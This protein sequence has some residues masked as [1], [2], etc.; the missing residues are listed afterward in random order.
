MRRLYTIQMWLFVS[1]V[2]LGAGASAIAEDLTHRAFQF[3]FA[4]PVTPTQY[5]AGRVGALAVWIFSITF[6]PAVLL[7]LALVGTA[8]S[9]DALEQRAACLD[10][11]DNCPAGL[12]FQH[13]LCKQ[14]NQRVARQGAAAGIHDTQPIA[15]PIE[16]QSKVEP[17]PRDGLPQIGKVG[18]N[19]GIRVMT[20]KRSINMRVQQDVTAGETSAQAFDHRAGGAVAGIPGDGEPSKRVRRDT[21]QPGEQALDVGIQHVDR[22]GRPVAHRPIPPGGEAAEIEYIWTEERTPV[23]YH[24]EAILIGGIVTA[25]YLNAILHFWQ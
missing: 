18:I 5:L 21:P 24:L 17:S 20:R 23:K 22:L 1:L 12:P 19:R 7:D 2:T 10:I 25:G 14:H 13:V 6:I 9:A 11:G 8:R 4:K 15:I 16:G 3:Y